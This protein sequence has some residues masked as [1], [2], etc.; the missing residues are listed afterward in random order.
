MDD[1]SGGRIGVWGSSNGTIMKMSAFI[2]ELLIGLVGHSF[3]CFVFFLAIEIVIYVF[4]VN[5]EII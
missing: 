1:V 5:F 2:L 4:L 3:S